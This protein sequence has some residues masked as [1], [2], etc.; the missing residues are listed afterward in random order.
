MNKVLLNN[1][2]K[3]ISNEEFI[4]LWNNS[5]YILESLYKTLKAMEKELDTVKKDDFDCPNHYAKLAYNAGQCRM[6]D[7]VTNL[8]PN[9]VKM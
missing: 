8:L 2:P 7:V 6:I 9:A 1:K 4:K 5:S 3:D